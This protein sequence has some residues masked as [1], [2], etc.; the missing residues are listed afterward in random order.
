MRRRLAPIWQGPIARRARRAKRKTSCCWPWSRRRVFGPPKKCCSNYQSPIHQRKITE[1]N[2]SPLAPTQTEAEQL[3]Q[4]IARFREVEASIV[5]QVRRVIVG[6]EE[7][8]QQVMIASV[9]D[10]HCLIIGLPVTATPLP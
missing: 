8:L 10:G 2:M 3:K 6:Q 5:K 7:G 1:N 4:R 9:V